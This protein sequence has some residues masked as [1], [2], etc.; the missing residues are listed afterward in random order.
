MYI[1]QQTNPINP[2]REEKKKGGEEWEK[3][4]SAQGPIYATSN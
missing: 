4:I 2:N 1:K 3:S